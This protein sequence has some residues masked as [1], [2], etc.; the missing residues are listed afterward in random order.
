M[1]AEEDVMAALN[2]VQRG[3]SVRKSGLGLTV[4]MENRGTHRKWVLDCTVAELIARADALE[5]DGSYLGLGGEPPLSRPGAALLAIHLD[6]CVATAHP[7]ST[8]INLVPYG[9]ATS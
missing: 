9:F 8:R 7:D 3:L 2:T 5:A 6:E 1:C 4:E